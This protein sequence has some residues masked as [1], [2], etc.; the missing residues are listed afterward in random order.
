[1]AVHEA[2][3]MVAQFLAASTKPMTTDALNGQAWINPDP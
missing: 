1:M 3:A 2:K